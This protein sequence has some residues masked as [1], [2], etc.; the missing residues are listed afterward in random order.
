MKEATT[1]KRGRPATGRA[2]TPAQRSADLRARARTQ[3]FEGCPTPL[4]EVAASVLLEGIATA[5]RAGLPF[6]VE[7]IADELLRRLGHSKAVTETT[8]EPAAVTAG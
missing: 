4:G 7:R 3:V 2:R 8:I 6:E 1:T 5:Y